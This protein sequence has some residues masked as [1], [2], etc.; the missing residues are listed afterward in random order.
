MAPFPQLFRARAAH[1]V[2]S[3][4]RYKWWVLIAVLGGLL[5]VNITF[6]ILAVAL[7]RIAGDFHTTVNTMTWVIT[8]P[9]LAFGITAPTFGKAGDIYGYKRLYLIGIAASCVCSL[10]SVLA[11]SASALIVIRTIGSIEG[12]ATGA[13]SIAIICTVFSPDDRVKA[14]GFWSLVGAGGPVIG[15][16]IGGPL[17]EAVGWGGLFAAPGPPPLIPRTPGPP[18]PP[19]THPGR[20]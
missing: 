17:L 15:V 16:A 6:T 4:D 11:W 14:M 9:L 19:P 2:H 10:L 1:R 3:S 20:R 7:T 12:A 8:G 13:A 18:R 5:S